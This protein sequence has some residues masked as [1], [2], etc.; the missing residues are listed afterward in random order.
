ME[1]KICI[2]VVGFSRNEFDKIEATLQLRQILLK[3]I[4]NKNINNIEIVSGYTSTG[5]PKIAYTLADEWGIMTVGFSAKQALGVQAGVYPVKKVILIGEKFGDESE[6]F[7]QYIDILIRIGGGKQSRHEVALF[8]LKNAEKD[9]KTCLFE[10]E[11]EW[12]GND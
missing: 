3:L 6:A 9:F 7:I 8:K 10:K 1:N 5:I 11:I 12:Y 2:G 4:E